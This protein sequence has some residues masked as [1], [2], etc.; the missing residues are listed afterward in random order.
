MRTFQNNLFV[1]KGWPWVRAVDYIH[2]HMNMLR[3][4]HARALAYAHVCTLIHRMHVHTC[5]HVHDL[6][7]D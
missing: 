7:V 1:H 4:V 2:V 3:H 6:E 5:T